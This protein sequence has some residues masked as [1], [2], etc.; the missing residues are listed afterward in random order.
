L[1]TACQAIEFRRPLK[2]SEMLEFAHEFVRRYVSFAQEDRIFA[3]DINK[4]TMLISDFSFVEACNAFAAKQNINLNKGFE[5]YNTS[6]TS[7]N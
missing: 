4:I 3:N 7:L 6:L 2:S 5:E 1:L